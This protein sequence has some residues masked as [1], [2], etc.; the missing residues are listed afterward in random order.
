VKKIPARFLFC[1]L[2]FF[3]FLPALYPQSSSDAAMT[4]T[5]FDMTGFPQWTRD[6]RRGEIV[7]F[8]AFPFMYLFTNLGMDFYRWGSHDWDSNYTPLRS[9]TVPKTTD[10]KLMT[11]GIAAGGAVCIALVDFG[12]EY[13]KR[14]R[15]ARAASLLPEGTPI[16]NRTPLN[17]NDSGGPPVQETGNP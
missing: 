14:H 10:E 11:L 15:R 2:L 13:F 17:A 16:I 6:L 7:A 3:A 9:G 1:A 12:I 4:S 5:H 8:G